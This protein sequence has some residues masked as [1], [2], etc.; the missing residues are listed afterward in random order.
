MTKR[1]R[2]VRRHRKF[3]VVA[4]PYIFCAIP[5]EMGTFSLREGAHLFYSFTFSTTLGNA[6]A[7]TKLKRTRPITCPR[8]VKTFTRQ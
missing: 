6:S 4:G 7:I 3:D 8:V 5:S 1:T 2:A